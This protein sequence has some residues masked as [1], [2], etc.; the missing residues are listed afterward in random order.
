MTV[1]VNSEMVAEMLGSKNIHFG[2]F[3]ERTDPTFPRSKKIDADNSRR[4]FE[5]SAIE[6]WKDTYWKG[7]IEKTHPQPRIDNRMAMQVICRGWKRGGHEIARIMKVA[8]GQCRRK[9]DG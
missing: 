5:K 1:M 8:N 6:A 3:L 9:A 4:Q 2:L 7:S